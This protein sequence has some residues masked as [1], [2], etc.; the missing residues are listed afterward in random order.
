M[1][2]L[3]DRVCSFTETLQDTLEN[4]STVLA[5][6][7]VAQISEQVDFL[8][9]TVLNDL[10]RIKADLKPWLRKYQQVALGSAIV[11]GTVGVAI[12]LVFLWFYE[13]AEVSLVILA[14]WTVTDR[15]ECWTP[16][17]CLTK[18]PETEGLSPT[19]QA[20]VDQATQRYLSDFPVTSVFLESLSRV[21]FVWEG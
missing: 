3:Q 21:Y 8:A 9:T 14:S 19:K 20:I 5:S 12:A 13:V 17:E 15:I 11:L 6:P 16:M 1:L 4:V 18:A 2:N 10:D 7:E